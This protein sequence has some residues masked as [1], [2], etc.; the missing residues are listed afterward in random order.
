MCDVLVRPKGRIHLSA[1]CRIRK[2][3]IIELG[4]QDSAGGLDMPAE[5]ILAVLYSTGAKKCLGA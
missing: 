1:G 3:N 2:D 4:K 5:P